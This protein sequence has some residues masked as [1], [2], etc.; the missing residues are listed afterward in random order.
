MDGEFSIFWC[1]DL[2]IAVEADGPFHDPIKDSKSDEEKLRR[3]GIVVLRVPNFDE[4]AANAALAFIAASETWR[5][6]RL[7][8]GIR[9]SLVEEQSKEVRPEEAIRISKSAA[10]TDGARAARRKCKKDAR[11]RAWELIWDTLEKIGAPM[12]REK[13]GQLAAGALQAAG[14]MHPGETLLA[15]S[16]RYRRGLGE[17][18][19]VLSERRSHEQ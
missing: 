8:L 13:N 15:W 12:P 11:N 4:L 1:A 2:G 7:R 18:R 16:T 14:L 9:T 6:R 19:E 10:R 3:N 17:S 5:A